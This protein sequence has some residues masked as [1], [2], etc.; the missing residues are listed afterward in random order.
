MQDAEKTVEL[1]PDWPKGYSR[2]GAALYGLEELQDAVSVYEKGLSLD[3]ENALL[4]KGLQDVQAAMAAPKNPFAKLFGP[5]VFEKIA[6]LLR[7]LK[8]S[9]SNSQST[10]LTLHG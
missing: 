1:K 2:K 9:W 5:D 4:K 7:K 8:L 3:P 6:G 10:N